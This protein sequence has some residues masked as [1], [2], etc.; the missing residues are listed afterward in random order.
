M[1]YGKQILY[2]R[3]AAGDGVKQWPGDSE[4]TEPIGSH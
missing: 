2:L 1:S 3:K 4:T